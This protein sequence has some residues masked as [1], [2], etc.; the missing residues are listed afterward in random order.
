MP[1]SSHALLGVPPSP[2]SEGSESTLLLR[3]EGAW[4]GD[5]DA[6]L[7]LSGEPGCEAAAEGTPSDAVAIALAS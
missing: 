5:A 2:G 1:P 7:A 6:E 3:G 4:L